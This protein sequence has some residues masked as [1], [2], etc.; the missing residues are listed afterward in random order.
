MKKIA[1]LALA[2]GILAFSGLTASAQPEPRDV[3]VFADQ[4]GTQSTLTAVDFAPFDFFVVGFELDNFVKA[5]EFGLDA[6]A[7]LTILTTVFAGPGPGNIGT[8]RNVI[9]FTGACVDGSSNLTLVAYNGGFFAPGSA[10]GV[11]DITLCIGP[12]S[13]SSFSPA[14]PGYSQCD[15]TLAPFGVAQNGM[16]QYPNGCMVLNPSGEV[17]ATEMDSFGGIKARF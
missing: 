1:I 9:A 6:P 3:G 16:P 10:S 12:A 8:P 17:V 4:A 15:N 5:Y 11:A 7:N 2:V 13:P 14:A